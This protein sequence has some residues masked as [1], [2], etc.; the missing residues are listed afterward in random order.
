MSLKKVLFIS[1]LFGIASPLF[2]AEIQ[3]RIVDQATKQPLQDALVVWEGAQ[4]VQATT[5]AQGKFQL[6][7]VAEGKG[8]LVVQYLGHEDAVRVL[9]LGASGLLDLEISLQSQMSKLGATRVQVQAEGQA[10]SLNDQRNALVIKNVVASD[11][12]GR[13]PD[14]NAAEAI[15]RVPGVDVTRDQ[16]EG[17]Y[18]QIRGTQPRMTAVKINGQE[19]P[20]PEGDIRAVALDVI[21]SSQIGSIEVVKSMLPEMD[22][23]GIGGQVD[24]RTRQAKDSIGHFAIS[25]AGGYNQEME[26]F[27]NFEGSLSYDQR[28]GKLGVIAG[29]SFSTRHQG[30]DNSEF[31]YDDL[32]VKV[33]EDSVDAEDELLETGDEIAAL[34]GIELRDYEITR[35]RMSLNLGLDYQLGNGSFLWFSAWYNRFSDQEYRRLLEIKFGKGD[36]F[37]AD[38]TTVVDAQVIRELKD[39]YEEQDIWSVALGGDHWFGRSKLDYSASYSHAGENT[40]DVVYSAYKTKINTPVITTLS[41]FPELAVL[42]GDAV[43]AAEFEFDEATMGDEKTTDQNIV[44]ALNFEFPLSKSLDWTLKMGGK[45]RMKQKERDNV[46]D[47]YSAIEEDADGNEIDPPTMEGLV[48]DFQD[49]D[50]LDGSYADILGRFV[51]PDD[52]R[53]YLKDQSA[54]FESEEDMEESALADYDASEQVFSGY[55]QSKLNWGKWTA[56]GGVRVE[57]TRLDLNGYTVNLDDES[58]AKIH[59]EGNYTNVLPSMHLKYAITPRTNVRMSGGVTLA[60]PDYYDLVPY[61]LEEDG[62]FSM[63]NPD[64]KT[65]VAQNFDLMAEHYFGGIGIVSA[66]Y[67]FKWIENDIYTSTVETED[68]SIEMPRNGE[69]G[70][71]HGLELNY[72][73]QLTFLPGIAK[74]FGLYANY[75]MAMSE[76]QVPGREDFIRMPGQSNHIANLSLGFERW[77]FST[78]VSYNIHGSFIEEV[79]EDADEDRWY[80]SRTQLDLS[81]SQ[82]L[83]EGVYLFAEFINL[84]DAPLRY[85]AGEKDRIVQQEY[86]GIT[87]LFGVKAN[88]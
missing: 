44:A 45:A 27:K 1:G 20:S 76:A 83:S 62:E 37:A 67:F 13:F 79:G 22:G 8:Q 7:G 40:P 47:V 24:L 34:D 2:A 70:Q 21:P 63:G 38:P 11:Q 17:R 58:I 85:Y 6:R 9:D 16:G 10:K 53:D 73:Q 86:Y 81:L 50:F 43:D 41:D 31:S 35:Q 77:G 66:G 29:A 48:D 19:V 12:I 65:S 4:N 61:V 3:G 82:E 72:T 80:D 59:D 74:S 60:R 32:A 25:A 88:F 52:F 51:N 14:Q 39:R 30:S 71:V 46:M 42:D 5:N 15:A 33:H 26:S 87:S 78:R 64:L 23:D 69:W 55:L 68:A 57:H 84:L 54:L 28:F 56:I 36:V 49:K 75:T 18:V